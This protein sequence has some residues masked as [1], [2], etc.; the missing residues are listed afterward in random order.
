MCMDI[1]HDYGIIEKNKRGDIVE[2]REFAEKMTAEAEKIIIGKRDRIE[3]IIMALLADGHILIEDMPGVGKTTLSSMLALIAEQNA[4]DATVHVG[5]F[6]DFLQG[7]TRIGSHDLFITEACEYV[8]SF[9]SLRPTIAIINNIDD[10]HLDR[11]S[12][13]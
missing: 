1:I 6:V 13:V 3:L 5:G 7:G 8:E 2:I 10:D 9:L 11:K 12:V 4:L